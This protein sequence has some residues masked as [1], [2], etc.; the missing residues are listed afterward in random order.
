MN[1]RQPIDSVAGFF[2]SGQLCAVAVVEH[3]EICVGTQVRMR[4]TFSNPVDRLRAE[5]GC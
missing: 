1:I 4:P 2:V 5:E 3:R